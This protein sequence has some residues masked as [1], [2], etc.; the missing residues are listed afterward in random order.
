MDAPQDTGGGVVVNCRFGAG[1]LETYFI[2]EEDRDGVYSIVSAENTQS[3][4]F[5]FKLRLG[6]EGSS[7]TFIALP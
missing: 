4:T 6:M 2:K 7:N 5:T 3:C 1:T